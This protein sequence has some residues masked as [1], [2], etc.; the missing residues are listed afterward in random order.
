MIA[1]SLYVGADA[2]GRGCL[3][4]R[5]Y[6]TAVR[7]AASTL[8]HRLSGPVA[9]GLLSQRREGRTLYCVAD[10]AQLEAVIGWLQV[11]CC[12]GDGA[13]KFKAEISAV[14][15]VCTATTGLLGVATR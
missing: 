10:Y 8:S 2:A 12:K 15:D 13:L 14:S 9:A 4:W 7:C 5:R 1:T 11:E 6:P 3:A